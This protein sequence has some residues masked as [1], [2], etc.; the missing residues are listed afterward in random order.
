MLK[1]LSQVFTHTLYSYLLCFSELLRAPTSSQAPSAQTLQHKTVKGITFLACFSPPSPC[2][3]SL[4]LLSKCKAFSFERSLEKR[5][6]N[7]WEEKMSEE[8]SSRGKSLCS[9]QVCWQL[10]IFRCSW[11]EKCHC[12]ISQSSGVSFRGIQ[13]PGHPTGSP[14]KYCLIGTSA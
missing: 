1:S 2:F 11:E 7:L 12:T 4:W 14:N 5:R 3:Q 9:P 10:E 6:C 13:M 8:Q